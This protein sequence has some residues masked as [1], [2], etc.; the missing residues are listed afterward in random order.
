MSAKVFLVFWF[1]VV[2]GKDCLHKGMSGCSVGGVSQKQDF[3][4]KVL[5][6][7]LL[8]DGFQA[9]REERFNVGG[10]HRFS[11]VQATQELGSG[12]P[13]RRLR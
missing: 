5:L 6:L 10:G 11:K 4:L 12:S 1:L 2:G 7:V 9:S 8:S 3:C 13:E